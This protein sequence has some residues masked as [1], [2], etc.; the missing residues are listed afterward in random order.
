MV[1]VQFGE[2]YKTIFLYDGPGKPTRTQHLKRYGLD[3]NTYPPNY[4]RDP[5]YERRDELLVALNKTLLLR[6]QD[7][8][9]PIALARNAWSHLLGQFVMDGRREK[10]R[11]L[12]EKKFNLL[13][14]QIAKTNFTP[15]KVQQQNE[16]L[17]EERIQILQ[18]SI[19]L[20]MSGRVGERTRQQLGVLNI[21]KSNMA[22]KGAWIVLTQPV[23]ELM[24]KNG[25]WDAAT[26]DELV[27]HE[28]EFRMMAEPP[29]DVWMRPEIPLV[30][31]YRMTQ[32]GGKFE[33]D[34]FELVNAEE[35]VAQ[36]RKDVPRTFTPN[37][38]RTPLV[39]KE[40]LH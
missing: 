21:I 37:S 15:E 4:V 35:L 17:L 38:L 36:V 5:G 32:R 1:P 23:V 20:T 27:V 19:L 33:N 18:D 13:K 28:A 26:Q 10:T 8:G 11:T 22:V 39:Q 16:Q 7:A 34:T 30:A 29:E 24:R 6:L 12:Q 31:R 9:L 14:R 2:K 40:L 3:G 25:L